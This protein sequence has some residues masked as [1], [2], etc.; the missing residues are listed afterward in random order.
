MLVSA[1]TTAQDGAVVE[2][3][4]VDVGTVLCGAAG[5]I[6]TDIEAHQDNRADISTLLFPV[7][8]ME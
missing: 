3:E 7:T 4:I 6:T 2:I 8:A 1:F 5:V